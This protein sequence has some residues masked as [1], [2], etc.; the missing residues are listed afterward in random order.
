MLLSKD[1]SR[2][3]DPSLGDAYDSEQMNRMV[4]V[5]SLCIQQ[6]SADRPQMSQAC[7]LTVLGNVELI[8]TELGS[9]YIPYHKKGECNFH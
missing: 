6:S 1:H 2:L 7:C 4:V 5:A 9:L 8:P 3:V